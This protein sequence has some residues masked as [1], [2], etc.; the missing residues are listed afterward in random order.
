M[1]HRIKFAL[2]SIT[3]LV[4]RPTFA[5]EDPEKAAFRTLYSLAPELRRER[6]KMVNDGGCTGQGTSHCVFHADFRYLADPEARTRLLALRRTVPSDGSAPKYYLAFCHARHYFVPFKW[7]GG[8]DRWAIVDLTRYRSS[9][10][11]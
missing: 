6:L 4:G 2:F 10:S 3:L 1:K 8:Q 9:S 11:K 5:S 7:G